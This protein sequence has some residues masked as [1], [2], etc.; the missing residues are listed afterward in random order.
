MSGGHCKYGRNIEGMEGAQIGCAP[1]FYA[2]FSFF[3]ER[4]L[5]DEKTE[6]YN[7]STKEKGGAYDS[8]C[9]L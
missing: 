1:V 6:N 5:E 7:K 8:N 2:F 3:C 9:S 4:T